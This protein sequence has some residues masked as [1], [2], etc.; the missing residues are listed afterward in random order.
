MNKLI[1]RLVLISMSLPSLAQAI[2]FEAACE[3]AQK[4]LVIGAVGDFL[5]HGPLQVQGYNTRFESIWSGVQSRMDEVDV[6]Y[7]NLETPVAAG[8]TRGRQVTNGGV[9]PVFDK[10]IYSGYPVFNTHE[11]LLAGIKASGFDILSTANN[12]SMD[13]GP[14]GI[15]KTVDAIESYGIPYS[16]TRKRGSNKSF[17]TYMHSGGFDLAFIACTFSL[18]GFND[19]NDQV[20]ECYSEKSKLIAEIKEAG[21][22]AD[23]VIVT[24]HWGIEYTNAPA[25]RDVALGKELLEAG[26]TA[27]VATHPHVIQP[28]RKHVT[29]DGRE[30]VIVFSTGNFISNQ[31]GQK[32][33]G[34]MAFIGLSKS[35]KG[36]WINGVRYSPTYMGTAQSGLKFLDQSGAGSSFTTL[37][38]NVMKDKAGFLPS[39]AKLV[40]NPECH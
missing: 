7:A 23:A 17:I 34:L 3:P 28:I 12:H 40:T 21:R 32:K 25:A 37:V 35:N 4:T 27:V 33:I 26:A 22:R 14:V 18:N 6:M 39:N 13:R 29:N 10:N 2:P 11:K 36:T 16:G 24:P 20:L 1:V 31:Q 15:D 19:P 30:G 9:R 8:V 5:M 38:E